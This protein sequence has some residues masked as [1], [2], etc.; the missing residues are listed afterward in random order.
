MNHIVRRIVPVAAAVALLAG[1]FASVA[2]A[3]G[4]RAEVSVMGGVQALN[5]NDTALPDQIVNIPAVASIAYHL[6]S[7]WALDGEFTWLIPVQQKVALAAGNEQDRKTP[8]I[9]AYQANV[10]AQ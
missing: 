2:A 9:L 7:N 5:K 1:S 6:T 4:A 10:R 8:D 3:E